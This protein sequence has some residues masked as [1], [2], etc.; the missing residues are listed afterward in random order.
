MGTRSRLRSFMNRRRFLTTLA[1]AALAGLAAGLLVGRG[2]GAAA[3]A[4]PPG[5]LAK[6]EFTSMSWPTSGTAAM[7]RRA[8]GTLALH[9]RNFVT[10][11]APELYV[12]LVPFVP[13]GGEIKGGWKIDNLRRIRGDWTYELPASAA[14]AKH[15]TVVVWCAMCE[16]P[17]GEA[18][19]ESSG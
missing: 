11:P 13:A 14:G 17:W 5:V 16:K 6:G 15:P 9:V 4:G 10:H 18:R 19:L 1:V 3:Q 12:Y 8:N 2:G 7:V